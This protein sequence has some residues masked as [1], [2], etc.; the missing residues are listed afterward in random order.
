MSPSPAWTTIL[1]CTE[2]GPRPSLSNVITVLQKD[3][4][5][6]P[7]RFWRDDF[8]DRVIVVNSAPRE[9]RDE[10][11]F[12][13]TAHIQQTTGMSLVSDAIVAKAVRLVAQQRAKH[14]VRDWFQSLTWDGVPRVETAF[15]DYWG[16]SDETIH[17]LT[18]VRAASLNFFIGAVA[19]IMRPG[20][21]LDTMPV[22]EGAQGS[23]KS[24]ALEI[25]AGPWFAASH[26]TM[27]TKD[28]L[29][30]MRGKWIIEIAE[31]QSFSRAEV[32]QIKNTMSTRIDT[33]RPPYGRA[34]VDFPRQCVFAGTTNVDSW[35]ADETGLRRFW[36]IRCGDIRLDLLAAAREQLFAEALHL[37]TVGASWWTMPDAALHVQ[38]TRMVQDAL[39]DRIRPLLLGRSEATVADLCDGMKITSE[40]LDRAFQMR[41]A[42]SLKRLGWTRQISWRE[43][44]TCRL[45]VP[46]DSLTTSLP[47]SDE[48]VM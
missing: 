8:L 17:P 5:F 9:W 15:E 6:G 47:T 30:S 28:F 43:G 13:F 37:F 7:D 27:G 25:L 40:K 22:F 24:S 33:Y 4:F 23:R 11:D 14:C 18:Y 29:V 34:T 39:T 1:D 21:K 31:L 42:D 20:C 32:T 26:E 45:W 3:P 10:D 12:T 46:V 36:P 44:K 19:R 48:E 35:G 16:V 38:G 41:I 2:R